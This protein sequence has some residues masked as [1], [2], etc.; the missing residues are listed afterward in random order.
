MS[1]TINFLR[2]R[3][4][5]LT[6]QQLQDTKWLRI[7]SIVA[8]G[9]LVLSLVVVG[10]Q[11]LLNYQRQQV[12]NRQESLKKQIMTHEDV[13]RSYVIFA[14][15]VKILTELFKQRS[16]KRTAINYFSSLF[17]PNVLISDISFEGDEGILQFGLKAKDIFT[18]QEVFTKLSTDEVKAQYA[19]INKSDL[20][21]DQDG[22]Y[23]MSV[24][25]TLAKPK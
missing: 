13:E 6:K 23:R 3:R 22:G 20:S 21:R 4:K 17:G 1:Y 19:S 2:H 9:V 18:L 16:D 11:L 24:T 15:K 8:G 10:G 25:I 12:L 14:N 7:S 5:E